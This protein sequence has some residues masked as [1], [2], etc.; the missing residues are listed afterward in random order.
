[1]ANVAGGDAGAALA[2]A[3]AALG[4]GSLAFLRAQPEAGG[5]RCA[6]AVPARLGADRW[7]ALLG[8]RG[9]APAD[10]LV[11]DAGS[12]LTIDALRADGR[13]LGGWILP[14]LAMMVG[15]L[16]ARTGDL[17][18]LR[19]VSALAPAAAFPADTGPAMTG[20]A[21]LAAAGAVLRARERL[22]ERVQGPVRLLLTGGDAPAL[23]AELGAGELV[24]DLVLRGLARAAGGG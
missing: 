13:H 7:A 15:A 17:A 9:L 4:G 11:I 10:C 14:G 23:A 8:A 20:G 18:E 3:L 22:G 21:L 6:Y 2:E 16:E 12:A 5:V 24:P 1:C 19:R